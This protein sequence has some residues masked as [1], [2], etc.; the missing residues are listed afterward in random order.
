MES[1]T[2]EQLCVLAQTGDEGAV[3]RLIKI[4]QRFIY[5]VMWLSLLISQRKVRDM[6]QRERYN[7]AMKRKSEGTG[8]GEEGAVSSGDFY[9]RV[10][11]GRK[12]PGVS[13]KAAVANRFC[14]PEMRLPPRLSADQWSVSMCRVSPPDLSNSGDGSSQDP[15]AAETVVSGILLCQPG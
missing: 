14:L 2:N 6:G 5:H 1:L 7:E 9:E 4:N 3:S 13:G 8:H 15:Y 10:W 11:H 12:V